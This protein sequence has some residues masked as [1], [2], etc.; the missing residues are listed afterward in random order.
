MSLFDSFFEELEKISDSRFI[1]ID[2]SD[3]YAD[4]QN[5]GVAGR[6]SATPAQI[7]AA[8]ASQPKQTAYRGSRRKIIAQ[9]AADIAAGAKSDLGVPAGVDAR[10][11]RR[12]A[13]GDFRRHRLSGGKR[14]D[15]TARVAGG[16]KYPTKPTTPTATV[17]NKI[18][19]APVRRSAKRVTYH[20]GPNAP[21]E[22]VSSKGG[23]KGV[24]D[25]IRRAIGK[26][27]R[28]DFY[29]AGDV[30]TLGLIAATTP[31]TSKGYRA[32]GAALGALLGPK[33][34]TASG[35]VLPR[36]IGPALGG[37]AGAAIPVISA[38]THA[39][40]VASRELAFRKALKAYR[41]RMSKAKMIGGGALTTA[42]IA[43]A[44]RRAMK[45]RK[46]RRK[47]AKK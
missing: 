10:T 16:F 27:K 1:D 13:V 18:T 43:E 22:K 47:K 7:A 42:A 34:T 46:N 11:A 3:E 30:A 29:T 23:A 20:S 39:G 44:S 24:V 38:A 8:K 6:G 15:F 5:M 35:R 9:R 36:H 25:R 41:S 12:S 26:P 32:A 19:P 45:A 40:A 17:A 31:A 37:A 2:M 21:K 14:K 33:A 28:S 4:E